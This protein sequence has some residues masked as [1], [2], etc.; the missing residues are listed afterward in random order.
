MAADRSSASDSDKVRRLVTGYQAARALLAADEI[1]LIDHLQ[2][3]RESVEQLADAM[4]LHGPPLKRF[5]QIIAEMAHNFKAG[6]PKGVIVCLPGHTA[7]IRVADGGFSQARCPL[8]LANCLL[9][10]IFARFMRNEPRYKPPSPCAS[11][12]GCEARVLLAGT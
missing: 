12:C 2:G 7:L 4:G 11:H 1:G 6:A 10:W 5:N 3:S 9:R 8:R